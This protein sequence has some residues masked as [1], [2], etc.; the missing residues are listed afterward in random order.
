[1]DRWRLSAYLVDPLPTSLKR[2]GSAG[3]AAKRRL[4]ILLPLTYR[5]PPP[6]RQW[7]STKVMDRRQ[8]LHLP[9]E[10]VGRE[11][12]MR[13]PLGGWIYCGRS[14]EVVGREQATPLSPWRADLP[15]PAPWRAVLPHG[16]AIGVATAAAAVTTTMALGAVMTMVASTVATVVV[17]SAAATVVGTATMVVAL[18]AR[19]SGN[20]GSRVSMKFF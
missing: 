6:I 19:V 17:A 20:W 16:V 4:A 11:Q 14:R 8:P 5:L 3:G 1:M 15:P 7:P 12:T 2:D 13:R 18:G 10:V 9:H